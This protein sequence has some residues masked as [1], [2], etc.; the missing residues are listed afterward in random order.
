M[1]LW[2]EQRLALKSLHLHLNT[3]G[4]IGLTAIA[5]LQ[6][7]LPTV[8]G[9]PDKQAGTR[10]HQDLKW[11]LGG[12]LLIS[13][14]AAWVKPLAY[15][16]ALLWIIPLMR[17]GKVWLTLYFPDIR[18]PHGAA[19]SLAAALIGYFAVLLFG[20]L[21]AA[22]ILSPADTAHA[23]ILAFLFPLVT[24]AVSYL[25]PIWAR[26]GMQ[27]A[28][29][30]QVRQRLGAGGGYRAVLF[31]AGGILLGLGWR[32]GLV[33]SV[34]ALAA[35]LLQLSMTALPHAGAECDSPK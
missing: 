2:P 19:S 7:L 32:G 18:Q 12:T 27:T 1:A 31:L 24:G 6:V 15:L 34:A 23:F 21:H 4:F 20:S 8:V 3:V 35:F 14:G 25:L 17:L 30:A 5:T 33:L 13:I 10:L 11:A 28:W 9:R 26:P 16:G 29:H 22:G